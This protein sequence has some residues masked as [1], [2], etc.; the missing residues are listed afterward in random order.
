M[1]LL[2]WV[3]TV[4][5]SLMMLLS[6]IMYLSQNQDM[7]DNFTVLGYPLYLMSILGI[8]KILGVIALLNPWSARL[9]DWA[10]AGFTFVLIGAV[11]SHI[12][13]NT[14]FVPALIALGLIS[15]SFFLNLKLTNEK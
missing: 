3:I 2:Y 1:K 13:T 11:L 10:Y 4:L 8:A 5:I 9:K 6:A 14:F 7:V 15:A 12:L